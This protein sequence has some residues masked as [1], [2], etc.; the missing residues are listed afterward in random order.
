MRREPVLFDLVA[1]WSGNC[2]ARCFALPA[3][4]LALGRDTAA[5]ITLASMAPIR[6]CANRRW[7]RLGMQKKDRWSEIRRSFDA[8]RLA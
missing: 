3:L 2:D 6:G 8:S 7:L 5:P 1:R 4:S